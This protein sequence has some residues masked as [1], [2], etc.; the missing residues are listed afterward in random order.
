MDQCSSK[1]HEWFHRVKP[2]SAVFSAANTTRAAIGQN[3]RT[4]DR[5]KTH[6]HTTTNKRLK[7]DSAYAW[8]TVQVSL[9]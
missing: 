5:A 7:D 3:R 9:L 6:K 1:Q 4:R 8:A 2:D